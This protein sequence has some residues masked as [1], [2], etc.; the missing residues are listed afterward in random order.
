M[1]LVSHENNLRKSS[2]NVC[3]QEPFKVGYHGAKFG[4]HRHCGSSDKAAKIFYMTLQ[5]TW[6][7][8][9]MILWK[10]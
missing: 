7:K 6:L 5:T 2:C 1:I 3:M 10:F 4:G 8:E 9:L